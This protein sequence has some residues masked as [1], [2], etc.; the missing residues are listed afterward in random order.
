VLNKVTYPQ[1]KRFSKNILVIAPGLTVRNRLE[2][3]VPGSA[4]NYYQEFQI[5]PPGLEDKLR[6][7]QT[8]RVQVRN[9][10]K[11][12]WDSEE[13][14]SKRRSVD[15]RG[16]LSD[17]AY[18]REVL[19][20]M[21]SAENL[22]VIN[23]EAHHAWR[24]P[25]KV[26]IAGLSKDELKEATKWVGGLDRI[27][28]ARGILMCYDLTATPFAPT[29]RKSGEETLFGWIVSDFGLN[30]AIE[31]GLVKTPRVVVRDDGE[32][33]S[34]Y[35]SKF[36]HIY[37]DLEVKPDLNRKAEPHTPLP[38]LVG[39]GYYFLGKD[40]LETAKAWK[41]GN[42][43]TPPVMI[44]VANLTHTAAR[45]Q[46]AFEHKRIR[47]EELCDPEKIL[48]IDSKVLDEAEAQEEPA[49]I[50][51]EA[52]TVDETDEEAGEESVEENGT[53]PKKKLTKKDRAEL[54]RK[55]VDTI[56]REGQPGEQIQNV[57]SVG[58][59][60]EGWD[61]K[62]VTHIMGLRA[63]TS[64]LLCEQVVGRGLRRTSYEV[65][66]LTGLFRPEYV[67]IFGVPF[68]FLPHEGSADAPPPPPAT[69]KTRIEPVAERRAQYE[70]T[71]PNV[72]RIDHEYRP[73]LTLDTDKVKRLVL[74]AYQTPM[75]AE[76][77]PMIDG[78]PDF[79]KLKEIHLEEL[80]RRF[81][82]Q[83]IVFETASEVYD[84]MA[85]TWKGSRE[86]LLAQL[87]RLVERYIDTGRVVVD[88]PLF[89][90]DDK[91]RR[92]VITLN[93]TKIVQHIWEAIRFEN[94]LTLEPVFDTE[95]P[96]RSTG[97]M[98]PW[99][100]GKACEHTKRSHINMCVYDSRW[101]AN[102]SLELDRNK[103][104]R[105]WVKNDHIGFE[106]TYSFKGIIH[107]FRPDYLVRLTNGKTLILEVK[108]Q[109]DQQQ[110]TKREFL[111][112]WVRAVNRHGGF[113]EWMADVSRH[114]KDVLEILERHNK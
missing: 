37:T 94:A 86:Y 28:H 46:Y 74:D 45:V 79:T 36:Y 11:L 73:Q 99:Y 56:G 6:Q 8:C 96:I 49:E 18:V 33:N 20:E 53:G 24:V 51:V 13:Q 113:G 7:G 88:P 114:P 60:S 17:E 75:I 82:M 19:G 70:M 22:L 47:I 23:D 27:H 25:P 87:V 26:K 48:H 9:W 61:A 67:N 92:I 97:D 12:D 29:G 52:A 3:L 90:E 101:E 55:T 91:R 10:H 66:E 63:F 95:R 32:L 100:S 40:W 68:T 44:T 59:L 109:D 77:A 76:L 108:G 80:A 81:R 35:K 84:L 39:K 57:I 15:K 2:V 41:E 83:R 34:K 38:D 50:L 43:K 89:N 102:E 105:A 98:L 42:I 112:E 21:H 78:K 14:I 110:Q 4:G 85:P 31:S 103:N 104:V 1:E 64:Q 65:D 16:A 54:L 107:K 106:I 69:G 62:T 5:I 30:D 72:I 71:W 111:S 58:M 93:M